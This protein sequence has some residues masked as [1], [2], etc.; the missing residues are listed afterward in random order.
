[1]RSSLV[2]PRPHKDDCNCPYCC[3]W[4]R[5]AKSGRPQCL[6]HGSLCQPDEYQMHGCRVVGID[7]VEN[8]YRV[9]EE[10]P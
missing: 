10:K 8:D 2:C 1:M 9:I 7:G 5:V 3:T 4:R 6:V